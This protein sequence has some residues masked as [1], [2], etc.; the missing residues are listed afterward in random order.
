MIELLIGTWKLISLVD[1]PEGGEPEYP[2]GKSP[3]GILTY[4]PEGYVSVHIMTNP[5]PEVDTLSTKTPADKWK[6]VFDSYVA[7]FG[8]YSIDAIDM[9]VVHHVEGSNW[10]EF[11][12]TSQRRRFRY[13]ADRLIFFGEYTRTGTK[14][15]YERLFERITTIH[16]VAPT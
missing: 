7:Y 2:H 11:I 6:E 9:I 4:T 3:K 15:T 8:T 12:G 16:P 13:S 1:I 14:Y 5:F 10:P